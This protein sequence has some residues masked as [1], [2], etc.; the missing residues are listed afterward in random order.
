MQSRAIAAYLEALES[1][2]P[3]RGRKRTSDSIDKR[4][5][6][7]YLAAGQSERA[8]ATAQ[9]GLEAAGADAEL[10]MIAG[11]ALERLGRDDEALARYRAALAGR[12]S[13]T[14]ALDG[15]I[16]LL[17]RLGRNGDVRPLIDDCLAR[18]AGN[19]AVRERLSGL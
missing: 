13:F 5:A 6:E 4:L 14:E 11:R 16:A 12:P 1:H 19:A 7:T 2:R 9:A 18:S 8:L 17:R 10:D 15:A 3:K